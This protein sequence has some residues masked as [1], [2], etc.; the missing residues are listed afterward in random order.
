MTRDNLSSLK[1]SSVFLTILAGAICHVS[2]VVA[3]SLMAVS[4]HSGLQIGW[5]P[6]FASGASC[7]LWNSILVLQ[8]PIL[9]SLFL[10]TSGRALLNSIY[11]KELGKALST[12]TYATFASLQII[13]SFALWSPSGVIWWEPHESLRTLFTLLY[14]CSWVFLAKSMA[15][16]GLGVQMGYL[17]WLSVLRGKNPSYSK[18]YSPKG[19][20]L[21][22]RQPMYLAFCLILWTAPTWTPDHLMLGLVWTAYLLVGPL[23]KEA[24]YRK[25][26]GESFIR[27]QSKV[28]YYLPTLYFSRSRVT[29]RAANTSK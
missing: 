17:G 21:F 20:F 11:P 19:C 2:F 18:D 14:G 15:D 5:G 10:T 6:T 4:I 27:Y 13:L 22:C 16:S 24:R 7:L 8:F 12:T 1:L 3:I 29:G 23:H 9:H 26:Y 25:I 28:P